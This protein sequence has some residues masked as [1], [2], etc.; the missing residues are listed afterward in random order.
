MLQLI[1]EARELFDNRLSLAL[2]ARVIALGQGLVG[3]IDGL[4]LVA[5]VSR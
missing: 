4:G 2:F 3:V 1:L 5:G